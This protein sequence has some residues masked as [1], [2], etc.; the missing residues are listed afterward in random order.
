MDCG[1]KGWIIAALL[2]CLTGIHGAAEAEDMDHHHRVATPIIVDTD[3]ALDDVR[4][5]YALLAEPGLEVRALATVE[6]SASVGR[7]TDN[8]A[9][10]LEGCGAVGAPVLRGDP[11][12]GAEAP[13]WRGRVDGLRGATFAPPRGTVRVG[14]VDEELTGQ[15]ATAVDYVAL[16]PLTNLARALA[17]QPAALDHLGTLWLPA[18]IREED[19]LDAWNLAFD[20]AATRTVFGAGRPVVLVDVLPTEQLDT[21]QI[22]RQLAGETPAVHW[23]ERSL[24]GESATTPHWLIYDELVAVALA[25]PDLVRM[26]PQRYA[27]ADAGADTFSL[28]PAADGNVQVA[29]IA[30]LD[31]AM[32]HLLDRWQTPIAAVCAHE[33]APDAGTQTLLR[34]FHGHLGPYVVL[35]YRMGQVALDALAAG[36]HFDVAAHVH[37]V[38]QPPAS[39]LIDGVQIGSGCTLGKRNIE[40]SA[41]DGPAFAVFTTSEDR[42]VTVRLRADV[43]G[44]VKH[45]VEEMGVEAAGEALLV[46]DAEELFEIE[47]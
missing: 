23:I 9:G 10:M 19:Q 7:G 14:R 21:V 24:A 43:P 1:R 37:S 30:D 25:R 44:R 22:L 3:M 17:E 31:A 27:L 32:A 28:V 12:D 42:Q 11:L 45:M 18:Q 47:P 35:G 46:E 2:A 29:E 40:V 8:L 16:G 34:T 36:G 41:T 33:S 13:P 20:P 6:G 38:L 15:L 39:C 5:I 26:R 4:A